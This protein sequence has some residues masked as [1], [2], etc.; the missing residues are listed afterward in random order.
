MLKIHLHYFIEPVYAVAS[1]LCIME[2]IISSL[3]ANFLALV[4]LVLLVNHSRVSS[5]QCYG[6]NNYD[7]NPR[8]GP[9]DCLNKSTKTDTPIEKTLSEIRILDCP[10]KRLL[11]SCQDDSFSDMPLFLYDKPL[12]CYRK[13]DCNPP[14][15][16]QHVYCICNTPLCN[17][18]T[19]LEVI[20]SDADATATNMCHCLLLLSA[21]FFIT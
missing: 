4:G 10:E 6:C 5:L 16:C 14:G 15:P 19:V 17:N 3:F 21:N 8:G 9:I 20:K 13:D 1:T 7:H 2:S 12:G 18:K 11:R